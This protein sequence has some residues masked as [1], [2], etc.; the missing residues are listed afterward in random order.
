MSL[1]N[2][3]RDWFVVYIWGGVSSNSATYTS[4]FV[5]R[6]WDVEQQQRSGI[7]TLTYFV[8][9][10][11]F[12]DNTEGLNVYISLGDWLSTTST[13]IVL[14]LLCIVFGLMVRWL[15]RLT[16]GLLRGN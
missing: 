1:W 8:N 6:M 10:G 2:I 9:V 14:T 7:S 3:I 11:G 15:F 4:N 12:N 16:A 13:I 5:G